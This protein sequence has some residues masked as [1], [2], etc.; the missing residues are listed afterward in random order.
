MDG[1]WRASSAMIY[2]GI[3]LQWRYKNADWSSMEERVCFLGHD[4]NLDYTGCRL[5][6][7]SNFTD[8]Q[9]R[10]F[11][12]PLLQDD[13][14]FAAQNLK[15]LIFEWNLDSIDTRRRMYAFGVLTRYLREFPEA[16]TSWFRYIEFMSP[17]EAYLT[18]ADS[19]STSNTNSGHSFIAG[20]GDLIQLKGFK[21]K[22]L[23]ET[24]N[25]NQN[26]KRPFF[27][28][29]H[30]KPYF[31]SPAQNVWYHYARLGLL[32]PWISFNK[33]LYSVLE[34]LAPL[35]EEKV[36]EFKEEINTVN[37]EPKHEAIDLSTLQ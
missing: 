15:D 36:K 28:F 7:K 23:L 3:T 1:E 9:T 11:I 37:K 4:R 10:Q 29:S 20:L 25:S 30:M 8:D 33:H 32:P 12:G 24:F 5:Q 14:H 2:P 26:L 27:Y 18:C 16:V 35:T 17:D 13:W 6:I 34:Q 21:L 19:T 31:N 22:N